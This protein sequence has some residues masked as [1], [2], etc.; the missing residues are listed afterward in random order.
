MCGAPMPVGAGMPCPAGP[1]VVL[2]MVQRSGLEQAW[3]EAE[4]VGELDDDG[5]SGGV[6]V[7][8]EGARPGLDPSASG[9]SH[10]DGEH[11]CAA[12]AA[13]CAQEVASSSAAWA[14]PS[15]PA[16]PFMQHESGAAAAAPGSRGCSP[17]PSIDVTALLEQFRAGPGQQ[18][19]LLVNENHAKMRGARWRAKELALALNELKRRIDEAK[20][21]CQELGAA[22]QGLGGELEASVS[23][24]ACAAGC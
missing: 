8:P 23:G 4:A 13:V 10:G 24:L 5:Q 14:Q 19:A 11:P 2:A 7:A 22:R 3:H 12:A 21:R 15:S 18:A 6:G 17:D 1:R 9:L 16:G 20:A